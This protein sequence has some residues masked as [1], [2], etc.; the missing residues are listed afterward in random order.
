MMFDFEL[1][2]IELRVI[3]LWRVCL[4]GPARINYCAFVRCYNWITTVKYGRGWIVNEVVADARPTTLAEQMSRNQ[5]KLIDFWH[6]K[7]SLAAGDEM[8]LGALES[9]FHPEIRIVRI[10]FH[11]RPLPLSEFWFDDLYF[12]I[13]DER[14][15]NRAELSSMQYRNE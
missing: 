13:S 4:S 3:Q 2:S 1:N 14:V 11:E 15:K 9:V 7:G 6:L 5:M 10:V 12:S 8:G